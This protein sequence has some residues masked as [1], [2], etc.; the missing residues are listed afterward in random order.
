LIEV[1]EWSSHE[2]DALALM[3]RTLYYMRP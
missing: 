1:L 3:N 2:G